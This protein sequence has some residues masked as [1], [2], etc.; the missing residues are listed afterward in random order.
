MSKSILSL[1]LSLSYELQEFIFCCTSVFRIHISI[2]P[3]D[4]ILVNLSSIFV[5]AKHFQ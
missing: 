3:S 1:H 2:E 5:I 4:P